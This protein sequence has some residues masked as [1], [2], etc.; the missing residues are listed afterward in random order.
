MPHRGTTPLLRLLPSPGHCHPAQSRSRRAAE[1]RLWRS[2]RSKAARC[3][4]P[5]QPGISFQHSAAQIALK[6]S[7]DLEHY[8]C[9]FTNVD[10]K[11][12]FGF[13]L[14]ISLLRGQPISPFIYLKL[15]KPA[16]MQI[17]AWTILTGPCFDSGTSGNWGCSASY[18]TSKKKYNR[19]L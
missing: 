11:R 13:I 17:L 19:R 10:W 18:S 9:W 1:S 4:H 14:W 2:C 3:R 15:L 12:S 5:A 7:S 16:P 8:I 6:N